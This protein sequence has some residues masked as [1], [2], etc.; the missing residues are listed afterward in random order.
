MSK[1][2]KP[3][4][5]STVALAPVA[6][7][8][9][10][11]TYDPTA[12]AA[13]TAALTVYVFVTLLTTMALSSFIVL[14]MAQRGLLHMRAPMLVTPLLAI[15]ISSVMVGT[16]VGAAVSRVPLR[17]LN[18]LI[19]GMNRLAAGRYD[20][21]IELGQS[22]MGREL[23]DSFNTMAAE[24]GNTEVLRGDFVNNFSHEFKTPIVSIRG[25]AK[26]LR[27][28]GLTEAQQQEYLDIIVE[29][30]TRLADMATNVLNLTKVE[31]QGILTD[32]T[33]FNLSEQLRGCVLLLEKKWA[34][35]RLTLAADFAEHDVTANEELLKQV[36]INLLDNAVKFSPEG[37][38][39]AVT[40]AETPSNV[41]VRITNHG[42]A[43]PPEA[44]KR[45]FDK[46]WQ[47]DP[48]HA[49]EGNGVGLSVVKRVVE[50]HQGAIAVE[51]DATA[52]TFA[53]TLPQGLR[54]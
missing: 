27:K 26:L 18:T 23:S 4:T 31:N 1:R 35:K 25:F 37:G 6:R 48:S 53:V 52:T 21:R 19:D 51:S 29:E 17:P 39:L 50:L 42:P 5:R 16:A 7:A 10:R 3:D 9:A 34:R 33:R 13:L 24:L 20:T 41:T 11:T 38:E 30:S 43:I 14:A 12:R 44:Q 28:G 49:A 8:R 45:I 54:P 47:G 32:V 46:F 15:A 36:W 40:I 2:D 22:R